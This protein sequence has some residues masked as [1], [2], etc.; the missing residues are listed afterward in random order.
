[1]TGFNNFAKAAY[2]VLFFTVINKENIISV[3]SPLM[4]DILYVF[5]KDT[6]INEDKIVLEKLK[7]FINID[8]DIHNYEKYGFYTSRNKCY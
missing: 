6:N 3:I 8:V 5:T 2:E 7:E 1:M 4:Q